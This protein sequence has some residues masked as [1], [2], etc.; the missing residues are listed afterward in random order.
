LK[1]LLHCFHQERKRDVQKI[2]FFNCEQKSYPFRIKGIQENCY[3]NVLIQGNH[4]D[5]PEEIQVS[6]FASRFYTK[7]LCLLYGTGVNKTSLQWI[8]LS[9]LG[10]ISGDVPFTIMAPPALAKMLSRHRCRCK[11]FADNEYESL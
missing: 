10:F 8:A 11:R 1:L 3:Y 4:F 7:F 2:S 9:K 5:H 6:A